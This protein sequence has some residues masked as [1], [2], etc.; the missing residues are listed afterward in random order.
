ME[1]VEVTQK[2][3]IGVEGG[4]AWTIED[5]TAS[6]GETSDMAMPVCMT[7]VMLRAVP[8]VFLV[9]RTLAFVRVDFYITMF[10]RMLGHLWTRRV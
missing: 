3:I 7:H 4:L 6:V 8:R 10:T 2:F 1:F 5:I 9:V